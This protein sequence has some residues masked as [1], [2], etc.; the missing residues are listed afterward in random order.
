MNRRLLLSVI[1]FSAVDCFANKKDTINWERYELDEIVIESFKQ[2]KK[3][4]LLP[5]STSQLT[6]TA[7]RNQL[8]FNTKDI[9][10]IIPNLFIPDYGSKYTTPVFIRGIGAKNGTPS[11]GLYVDGIPY[12]EKSAFDFGLNEIE[13]I[14][15]FR[16]PQGTL[17]GRNTMGGLINITT[18]S[19]LKHQYNS[20]QMD[21]GSYGHYQLS[22]SHY[23]KLSERFGY[24]IS[25]RYQ[26]NG[27]YFT[28]TYT[29]EKADHC[30]SG[31]M[32]VRL[33]WK[34]KPQLNLT[35]TGNYDRSVQ[36]ANAYASLDT[37]TG[38]WN[39]I[40]FNNPSSYQRTLATT[41]AVLNY[42]GDKI[43]IS[44]Q[45]SL[46]YAKDKLRQDQDFTVKNRVNSYISQNQLMTSGELNVK[47]QAPQ[48]Y[49]NLI[50]LFG[51]YQHTDKDVNTYYA[52]HSTYKNDEI[53]TMGF[54]VYH[55]S[56]IEDLGLEGL[57]LTLGIRYDHEHAKRDYK[58]A[59][60]EDVPTTQKAR[61]DFNQVI[62][63]MV[64]QYVFP[65][66]GQLYA[67]IA[68]GYKAGGFNTS[69]NKDE[70]NHYGPESSWNYEIGAKHPFWDKK[71]TAE[72][73]VY[74]IAW[75]NQQIQQKV[76]AGGFMIRNAGRSESKGVE[77]SLQCN[78]FNGFMLHVNYGYTH[79]TFKRYPYSQKID[80]S[81]NYLPLVPR[82]TVGLNV[83]YSRSLKAKFIERYQVGVGFTGNG[84]IYW[85]ENNEKAQPFYGLLNASA[86]VTKGKLTLGIW[87]KNISNTHY[88][89]Y[90]F[91]SSAGI[92]GQQGRP[93]TIGGNLTVTI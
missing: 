42:E 27:G 21:A 45:Q 74:W 51:F 63:K 79:A 64:V 86:S 44:Y 55:Q 77:F 73:A 22:A 47:M 50:G 78:P 91:K 83:N 59:K 52:R 9:S 92:F 62:P 40:A 93:F 82:H 48:Y 72:V 75:K 4:S 41:G 66:K 71:L 38:K 81:G 33:D 17:Y 7:I 23:N 6:G 30:K 11:V 53:P 85:H 89:S 80:Y 29:G 14:E 90:M 87:S 2:E 18:R 67:S 54:A 13:K 19:P 76:D 69:F 20:L 35:V 37:E 3:L 28:N 36:G 34:I 56:I 32:R 60:N 46:Q 31:N 39:E 1:I 61:N 8:L 25:G 43:Q 84:K 88:I 24:S 5:A 15:V 16:G 70:E 65:V 68:K 26:Q 58:Y 12:F 10:A 57:S 49:R